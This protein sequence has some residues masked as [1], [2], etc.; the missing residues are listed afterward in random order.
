MTQQGMFLESTQLDLLHSI[1]RWE[2]T[3]DDSHPFIDD[4]SLNTLLNRDPCF[5]QWLLPTGPIPSSPGSLAPISKR[6]RET[7]IHLPDSLAPGLSQ[8]MHQAIQN[9]LL[10]QQF[11]T[12]IAKAKRDMLY[13][14]AYG[15]SHEINNPLANISTRA[16]VLMPLAKT[17]REKQLLGQIVDQSQRAF[18]MLGDLMQCAK[19]PKLQLEWFEPTQ[20]LKTCIDSF[21]QIG[22]RNPDWIVHVPEDAVQI[23]SDKILLSTIIDILLQNSLDAIGDQGTIVARFDAWPGHCEISIQDTGNGLSVENRQ[24][25]FDPFYSGRDAGRGIGIG[26]CKANHFAH[27]LRG[28]LSL[29][30]QANAGCLARVRLPLVFPSLPAT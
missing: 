24:H 28:E 9:R 11:A 2:V 29:T 21:I 30:G 5:R 15:L 10:R 20:V 25:A 16:Q 12:E 23:F 7:L 13:H 17:D 8:C 26:L 22:N 1:R 19:S 14:L 18:E 4:S 27:A 6:L 3:V